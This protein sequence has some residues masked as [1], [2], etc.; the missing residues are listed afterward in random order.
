MIC[1]NLTIYIICWYRL[2][3]FKYAVFKCK[4]HL[5]SLELP[6]IKQQH[7]LLLWPWCVCLCVREL[8]LYINLFMYD[9]VAYSQ[10]V[11]E[12]LASS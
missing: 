2:K 4:L 5:I 6:H 8:C 11:C 9:F 3:H 1:I 7:G 12:T 10:Y